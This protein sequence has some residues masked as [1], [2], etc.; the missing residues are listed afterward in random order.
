MSRSRPVIQ[1]DGVTKEF[2]DVT[3]VEDINQTVREGEFFSLLGPSG[4]G[5]TTTLRMISGLETPTRGTVSLFDNDVT[6]VP[7]QERNTNLVFQ[8]LALFPHM[9]VEEN[10]MFGLKHDSIPESQKHDRISEMLELV[11]LGGFQERNVTE[12]SGGQQQRVALARALAKQP[13]VL[14]LDEPLGSLDR[15]LRQQM[16]FDLKSIQ[17]KIGMTFFYV[18]HDQEVAMTMSDRMAV[19]R[20]GEI[21]QVGTPTE[22]YERPADTFVADFIGDANFIEGRLE[23]SDGDSVFAVDGRRLPVEVPESGEEFRLLARPENLSIGE[24]ATEKAFTFEAHV[25]EV[26]N[27]GHTINFT[28]EMEG[29]RRVVIKQ[30]TRSIAEGDAT[31]VGFDRTDYS[32]IPVES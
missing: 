3:A 31:T 22:V 8:N 17:K 10:I 25:E 4:C 30:K 14:L 11:D 19:M 13:S 5:K 7:P 15:K 1:L 32:L 12:L 16:Q 18:T 23:T 21:I 29:S 9:S 28:V 6:D 2:G 27:Q 26:I 20:D 24:E